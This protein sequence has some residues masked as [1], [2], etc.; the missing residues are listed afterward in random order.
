MK[1]SDL[2]LRLQNKP[3]AVP[4]KDLGVGQGIGNVQEFL[5]DETMT[6][7][8]PVV[9]LDQP[10]YSLSGTFTL[11]G[12]PLTAV[13]A[14]TAWDTGSGDEITQ[15]T[16]ALSPR[17]PETDLPLTMTIPYAA[18]VTRRLNPSGTLRATGL[19]VTCDMTAQSNEAWYTI[20]TPKSDPLPAAE[21]SLRVRFPGEGDSPA[22]ELGYAALSPAFPPD[23]ALP[24]AVAPAGLHETDIPLVLCALKPTAVTVAWGP[25]FSYTWLTVD[26]ALT[27]LDHE[28]AITCFFQ[29]RQDSAGRPSGPWEIGGTL[30]PQGS[31]LQFTFDY[32]RENDTSAREVLTLSADT[33]ADSDNDTP[34]VLLN[35]VR[36]IH[37][38]PFMRGALSLDLATGVP[39]PSG[40]LPA[41]LSLDNISLVYDLTGSRVSAVSATISCAP[42]PNLSFIPGINLESIRLSFLAG[43]DPAKGTWQYAGSLEADGT[44]GPIPQD[45]NTPEPPCF[46]ASARFP[47][48]QFTLRVSDPD[49]LADFD[50]SHLKDIQTFSTT[51]SAPNGKIRLRNLSAVYSPATGAYSLDLDLATTFTIGE[52][53]LKTSL[54]DIRLTLDKTTQESPTTTSLEASATLANI[55]TTVAASHTGQTWN[56]EG[57]V[58]PAASIGEF[59]TWLQQKFNC[60]LPI[61]NDLGIDLVHLSYQTGPENSLAFTCLGQTQIF[62]HPA[63]YSLDIAK[64]S[65]WTIQGTLTV[66]ADNPDKLPMVFTVDSTTGPQNRLTAT[67]TEPTSITINDLIPQLPEL[68]LIG[69]IALTQARLTYVAE[70]GYAIALDTHTGYTQESITYVSLT[71]AS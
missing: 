34:T 47:D 35:S 14:F 23:T 42:G 18:D 9:N 1:L 60:S 20:H 49:D 57:T 7:T 33:T 69:T 58:Q 2:K 52:G 28:C 25:A 19:T 3:A 40:L 46:T 22:C 67:W 12:T 16:I 43:R 30:Q 13:L 62:G 48:W 56:I 37:D 50:P 45:H 55:P 44:L 4:L 65:D 10:P 38:Q 61:L 32:T 6:I 29:Q 68:P 8:D 39:L 54:K 59:K 63:T 17:A 24:V 15:T 31:D 41:N 64:A 70:H 36:D 26:G 66:P 71:P 5:N 53:A 51:G 21:G 11:S 27:V